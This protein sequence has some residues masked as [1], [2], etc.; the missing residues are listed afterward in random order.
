MR[1][2]I[3]PNRMELL[4]LKKRRVLAQRGYDLLQDKL[5]ELIAEFHRINKRAVPLL[6]KWED[7]FNQFIE[8][9]VFLR[10][11][12]KKEDI[13]KIVE[14]LDLLK[15][16]IE[17]K[18]ILN[19][20]IPKFKIKNFSEFEYPLEEI[21]PQFDKIYILRKE[22]LEVSFQVLE[23]YLSLKL[24][25]LEIVKTRR[26]VNALQY[27]LIPTI[28]ESIKYIEER[29]SE[30]EREFLMRILRIKEVIRK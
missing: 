5:E 11:Q 17:F 7:I 29:L 13:K 28:E 3:N 16:E 4:R 15:V 8:E 14:N 25:S 20:K 22:F 1:L 24:I 27:I 10:A 26:R 21:S 19:L 23:I 6:K 2:K 18:R 12:S 30:F 9:L